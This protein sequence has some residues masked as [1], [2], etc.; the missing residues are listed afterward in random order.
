[1]STGLSL[2]PRT[3]IGRHVSL[4]RHRLPW[5]PP[6]SGVCG[7]THGTDA[8]R[9]ELAAATH[10][11]YLVKSM[12]NSEKVERCLKWDFSETTPPISMKFIGYFDV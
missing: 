8:S 7:P 4:G 11:L 6:P 2:S 3:S 12:G 5:L 1:M 10:S 9:E